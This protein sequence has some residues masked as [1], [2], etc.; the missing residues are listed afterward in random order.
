MTP[1]FETVTDQ[2]EGV[3]TLARRRYG[4]ICAAGRRLE[5]IRLRPFPKVLAWPDFWPV[6]AKYHGAGQADRCLLYYNQPRGHSNF[7]AL[8]YL[9]TTLG[10]SYATACVALSALDEIARIK[11]TDALLCDVPG[12]RISDRLLLRH[13]WEPHKPQRWHRNYIKRFYGSYPAAAAGAAD[14]SKAATLDLPDDRA[15][16]TFPADVAGE[17]PIGHTAPLIQ[18]SCDAAH[19]Y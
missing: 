10:T 12:S 17:P 6:G 2:G 18:T 5:S 11:R 14:A 19:R 13:G 4:V 1:W 15:V 7:I 9:V 16:A 8:R 3:Q